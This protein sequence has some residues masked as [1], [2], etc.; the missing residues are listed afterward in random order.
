MEEVG[1]SLQKVVACRPASALANDGAVRVCDHWGP[2]SSFAYGP[3]AL[4]I[5][6]PGEIEAYEFIFVITQEYPTYHTH[7]ATDYWH[8]YTTGVERYVNPYQMRVLAWQVDLDVG[9]WSFLCL[10]QMNDDVQ[11]RCEFQATSADTMCVRI[12]TVNAT[13]EPCQLRMDVYI[14]PVWTPKLPG[15]QADTVTDK[16]AQLRLADV[17]WQI[18]S[19]GVEIDSVIA[20]TSDN[21]VTF[22][23]NIELGTGPG[24]PTGHVK[25]RVRLAT[26]PFRAKAHAESHALI[27]VA[28]NGK[29][30]PEPTHWPAWQ[31]GDAYEHRWWETVH[32]QQY[33]PLPENRVCN[34][35]VTPAP[36]YARYYIWDAGMTYVGAVERSS[37]F[38]DE[39]LADTP[40]PD[41]VGRR[42]RSEYGAFLPT[43]IF[44]WWELYCATGDEKMLKRHYGL[45]LRLLHAFYQYG[46][47]QSATPG[48]VRTLNNRI[49]VDDYP[50]IVYCSGQPFVWDY[51]ETLPVNPSCSVRMADQPA[52]TAL[53]IRWAKILR[54]AAYVLGRSEDVQQLIGMI[55]QS[56][57]AINE[58]LWSEQRG[59]YVWRTQEDGMLPMVGL[60][61][62]YPLLSGAV[63]T[64]RRA[65][66]LD[67]LTNKNRGLWTEH[68][69]TMVPTA[70]PY[71]RGQGY[72]NGAIW[73]PPQWLMWKALYNQA[74]MQ[75]ADQLSSRVLHLIEEDHARTRCN[76]EHYSVAS[77]EGRGA[78]RFSGLSAAVLALH[79]A[80]RKPGRIQYGQDVL[81]EASVNESCSGL[82]GHVR[83]PFGPAETG[84]S[85]VLQPNTNYQ[86]LVNGEPRQSI[87]SDAWGYMSFVVS[88]LSNEATSVEIRKKL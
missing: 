54:L 15:F 10:P 69:V 68:G 85:V 2:Y 75:W 82:V 81:V 72:W 41:V 12:T 29:A 55:E 74:E 67:W 88:G 35:R 13:D 52:A 70:S 42:I 30:M 48:L 56:E 86:L 61:G 32:N 14:A 50:P 44:A 53:G 38:V 47:S 11:V 17:Q 80:R 33:H 40:D 23:A 43:Q 57:L 26:W 27:R 1:K 62:C 39:H 65:S 83:S 73:M 5:P 21:W 25:Q 4:Y 84:M 3:N 36:Q 59:I 79:A 19:E 45:M 16:A 76:W 51:V 34:L 78:A 71:Y 77:G 18:A 60:D 49:G 6:K 22:P 9:Y 7:P 8:G 28:A 24:S 87:Q 58:V 64:G 63:P 31:Q 46:T 37:E 66:V 20:T